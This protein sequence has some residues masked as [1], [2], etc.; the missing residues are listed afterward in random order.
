[1]DGILKDIGFRG[2]CDDIRRWVLLD[3][4]IFTCKLETVSRSHLRER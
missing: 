2:V 4:L 3:G 1:M